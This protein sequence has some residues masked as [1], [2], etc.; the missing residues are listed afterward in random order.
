[1]A[2]WN[3]PFEE[4]DNIPHLLFLGSYG[5]LE[6]TCPSHVVYAHDRP[7]AADVAIGVT[8]VQTVVVIQSDGNPQSF[9][10]RLC[11]LQNLFGPIH[12]HEA[13]DLAVFDKLELSRVPQL[14]VCSTA[15]QLL[16]CVD[17]LSFVFGVILK[18]Y[19]LMHL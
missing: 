11:P 15:L 5:L 12:P 7:H 1:M 19:N 13:V 18:A 8:T 4:T 6:H 9:F 16:F 3:I 17:V 14:V 2:F 10:W